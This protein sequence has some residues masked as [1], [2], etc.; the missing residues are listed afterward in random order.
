MVRVARDLLACAGTADMA[1]DV[2]GRPVD[3]IRSGSFAHHTFNA[4]L[5]CLANTS[6]CAECALTAVNLGE[7]MDTTTAVAG[8]C[9]NDNL[10]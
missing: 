4:T 10:P 8:V 5:W 1:G 3:E 9:V 2:A 7:E 6:S